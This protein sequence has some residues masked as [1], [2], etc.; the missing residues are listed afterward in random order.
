MTRLL[1]KGFTLVEVNLAIFIMAGGILAMISLYT[2]GY[3]ENRQSR[4]DVA[5]T[6]C[7]DD[8]MNRLLFALSSTN[9]TWSTWKKLPYV[10]D[11]QRNNGAKAWSDYIDQNAK[12]ENGKHTWRVKAD[13]YSTAQQL[14]NR[15]GSVVNGDVQKDPN[16]IELTCPSKPGSGNGQL[17]FAL[18]AFRDGPDS[19]VMS[20]SM[21]VVRQ[22]RWRS[23]MSQPIFFTEVHFHGNMREEENL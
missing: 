5:S 21:R 9:I 7:A 3:R 17:T 10:I 20:I 4:E 15:I 18:V 22:Q 12:D 2:L 6:A 23:L 8:V 11:G 1:K 13:P 19:P 16:A 14:F